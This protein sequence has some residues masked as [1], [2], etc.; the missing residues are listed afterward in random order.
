LRGARVS[1]V[2]FEGF[3]GAWATAS[4]ARRR[5]EMKRMETITSVEAWK[6]AEVSG[7]GLK[8]AEEK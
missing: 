4:G 5:R 2:E 1:S 7:G 8:G 3:E 6:N